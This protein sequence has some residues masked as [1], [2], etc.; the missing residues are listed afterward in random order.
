MSTVWLFEQF[1]P[2]LGALKQLN[3]DLV[4]LLFHRPV[5]FLRRQLTLRRLILSFFIL[6]N[7]LF[8]YFIYLGQWHC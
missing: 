3:H 6:L 5:R 7:S 4:V 1:H 2:N 8:Y